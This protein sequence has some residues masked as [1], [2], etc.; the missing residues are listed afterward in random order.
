MPVDAV[1]RHRAR[2]VLERAIAKPVHGKLQLADDLVVQ[3]T[4]DADVGRLRHLLQP[5]RH[6]HAVAKQVAAV[7]HDVAEI[8]A[9]AELHAPLRRE[10]GVSPLQGPLDGDRCPNRLHCTL[11]FCDKAIASGAE[12]APAMLGHKA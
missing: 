1:H 4:G 8:E 9:D 6:I 3:R 10:V 5:R 7:D 11:E 12:D 2:H